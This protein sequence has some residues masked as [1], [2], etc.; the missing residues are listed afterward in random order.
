MLRHSGVDVESAVHAV[1]DKPQLFRS[2]LQSLL[3]DTSALNAL[4][5]GGDVES[6]VDA[7]VRDARFSAV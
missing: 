5:L 3:R 6:A 1:V 4:A 7:V 2:Y